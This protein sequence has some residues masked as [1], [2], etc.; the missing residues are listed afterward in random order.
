LRVLPAGMSDRKVMLA[1]K[2][3]GDQW[4]VIQSSGLRS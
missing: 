4:N 3:V 2:G 1:P